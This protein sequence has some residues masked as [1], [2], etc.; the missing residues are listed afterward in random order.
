MTSSQISTSPRLLPIAA[1]AQML[2]GSLVLAAA[3]DSLAAD[4]AKAEIAPKEKTL[5]AVEV[6]ASADASAEGLSKVYAGGQVARGGRVGLL[7]NQELMDTP[8]STSAYTS[9]LIQ[10]QQ[11]KSVADVL[12]NDP[13]VRA[14]RGFGNFQELYI[15]RG[16]PV[17]SDDMTYNGLYG[18]LP[19]QYLAAEL[20]ERVEVLRGANA[21]LN[22][23]TGAA[24]G[25]GIGG[26][27]NVLPKRAGNDPLNQITAGIDH[28]GHA[29][30][31][32][33]IS[34]RF[35]PD[36]NTGLRLN[37]AR[38]DGSGT[39]K[40][41]D[42]ELSLLSI[43]ADFR[44]RDVRLSADVGYQDH[45][46][47]A[48]RPSVTP[49]GGIPYAPDASSNFAQAWTFTKEQST[50]A[51]ARAE[52]DLS[53]TTLAWAAVGL[54][55]GDEQNRLTNL[56]STSAG[57]TSAYRFDNVREDE[58]R[59]G[60]VGLRTQ[61]ST[62]NVKHTAVA[63]A[64]IYRLSSRNAYAFSNFAGF[65]NNLYQPTAV[66][67]PG[68]SFFTGGS[69]SAPLV[70]ERI[71]STSFALA[72]TLAF[73]EDKLKLTL[74]ARHQRLDNTTYNYNTG[75]ADTSYDKSR[76]TPMAGLVFRIQPQL[77]A[78]ANY[79]EGLT[80]GDRA[81]ASF[82]GNAVTNAGQS[83]SP[84]VAKQKEIGIKYDGNGIGA[85][86]ALFSTEKPFGIY[87][88]SNTFVAGGEQRNQ[89]LEFSVFGEAG[90]GIRL[91][92]GLTLLDA[93]ITSSQDGALNG[94]R[95]IGVPKQQANIGADV[96]VPGIPGLAAN[97]RVV[98]TASQYA[99][100]SNTMSIPSWTRVDVGARYVT[101]I[102]KQLVTFR[103]RI[104]NLLDNNYWASTGGYPG[105][106]YLVLGA[107]R[108]LT[109]TAT[110]DF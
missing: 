50:F 41:E 63:S 76:V 12:L 7:G 10:D 17:P 109:L 81:G 82:N 95:A 55:N 110:A 74:G 49:I 9:Q 96:D 35:G 106:S 94:N 54:R 90:R 21:F 18:V 11:A 61:F 104:D 51:T 42:R 58:I 83:L 89:G 93:K 84:Y 70:T 69:M 67:M 16:F 29:L 107:P 75:A 25:F 44:G 30:L 53:D 97:A 105:A 40:N 99:D 88:A 46:I 27:V 62:G 52:F 36:Q 2:V 33:D 78:Y 47:N 101:E 1:A 92:G 48:P 79:I 22:G 38:R 3:L 28:G 85:G 65:A 80:K 32:T 87:D 98:Y 71:D 26:S 43:G 86:V 100:A 108:T 72:D 64:A 59:T 66:A 14:A 77:S 5:G 15:I 60:E 23:G 8:V 56:S 4:A 91:L 73:A 24:S 39:V 31:S 103:A 19:R 13:T 45:R 37:A 57:I 6:T 68:A 34:R 20:V 102:N